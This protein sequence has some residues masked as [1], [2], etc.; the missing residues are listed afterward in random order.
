MLSL[1][2]AVFIV[3]A[4]V[5]AVVGAFGINRRANAINEVRTASRQLLALQDI[6]VR[7]VHADAIASSSY[8]RSGQEDPAQRTA[9][10]DE[11]GKAGDGLVAV[12]AAANSA[13]LDQLSSAS[14]LLGSYVGLV[15]QARANNRQGFPVGAAYQRQANGIVSNAD[16][17]TPDIVSSLRAVEE[18][19]RAQINDSL[20]SAHRAGIWL[21]VTGWLLFAAL[22]V[23]SWWLWRT[24]R[25]VVN[26]PIAVALLALFLL[27]LI[28]GVKQ[29]G[30]VSDADDAVGTQ[31]AGADRA[32]Q[33]RAAAFEARS[34]EALTLINRGNGAAN[35][36]N[37][38]LG[39]DIVTREMSSRLGSDDGLS[40]AAA[41]AYASYAEAHVEIRD[42]DNKG[43]WDQA[44]AVS[45]GAQ[46]TSSGVNSASA[47]DSFDQAVGQI[48]T[49]EGSTASAGLNSA[50]D[51]L[52]SLR[53]IVF[54][55]GL[56]IAVL[57]ALG[58]GQRLKE[59]R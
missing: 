52:K 46:S 32:A 57:A 40:T 35:E 12:S 49:A 27:L 42:L 38:E 6:Q 33:A 47:F 11:I 20:A 58:C 18:S 10:L 41:S 13:D 31:L 39:N 1:I 54:L 7:I 59:Y 34:Q 37:W 50:V 43:D 3:L 26:V 29:A 56:V 4:L 36:V 22:V 2:R 24:F 19:Q 16:P 45:L 30:A 8:L 51:P 21:N 17:D 9:Y 44:V 55:A 48:A 5:F 28:G 25:R 15:E 14:R 53:N 23:G